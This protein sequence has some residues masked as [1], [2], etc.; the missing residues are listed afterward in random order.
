M[1]NPNP[2]FQKSVDFQG[3]GGGLGS[4]F[5]TFSDISLSIQ[6]RIKIGQTDIL[7]CNLVGLVDF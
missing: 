2:H 1:S 5:H 6:H 7:K 3:V 4:N